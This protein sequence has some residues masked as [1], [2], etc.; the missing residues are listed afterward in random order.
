MKCLINY[1]NARRLQECAVSSC[2][3]AFQSECLEISAIN[4]TVPRL[5]FFVQGHATRL[6]TATGKRKR[7]LRAHLDDQSQRDDIQETGFS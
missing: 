2:L 5:Y 1:V 7:E 4:C 3:S 6:A